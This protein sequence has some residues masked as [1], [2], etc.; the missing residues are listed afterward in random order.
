MTRAL[1]IATLLVVG[2][3]TAAP[4]LTVYPPLTRQTLVGVWEGLFIMD[5]IA[6][7]LHVDIAPEDKNSYLVEITAGHPAAGVFRLESCTVADGKVHLEFRVADGRE[8]W[9]DGEGWA[10]REDGTIRANFGTASNA[11][12]TGPPYSLRFGKGAWTRAIGEAS[13]Q[14]A[15]AV[16]KARGDKK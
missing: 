9:I 12:K 4:T 15:E 14:A 8:W 16:A 1:L 2:A 6:T 10:T 11:K 13:L 5:T 7:V 3:D